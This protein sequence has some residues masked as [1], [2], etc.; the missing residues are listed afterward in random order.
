MKDKKKKIEIFA[1]STVTRDG[2]RRSFGLCHPR[3]I[4][5]LGKYGFIWFSSSRATRL[6]RAAN[7]RQQSSQLTALA[8]IRIIH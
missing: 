2:K 4:S 8:Y 3:L 5:L 6:L 7:D 1:L